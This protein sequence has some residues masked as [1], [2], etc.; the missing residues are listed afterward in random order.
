MGEQEV[1]AVG[2]KRRR[3]AGEYS[4]KIILEGT[5]GSFRCI[6]S[7]DMRWD[8]LKFAVVSNGALEGN[9]GFIVHD[10]VCRCCPNR[11]ET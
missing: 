7:V 6:S 1:P 9:A 10:V 5:D 3:R 2:R 8:E 4:K 11:I